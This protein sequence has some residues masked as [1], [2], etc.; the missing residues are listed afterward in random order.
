MIHFSRLNYHYQ[1]LIMVELIANY[2]DIHNAVQQD[3]ISVLEVIQSCTCVDRNGKHS[4]GETSQFG[5]IRF[6]VLISSTMCQR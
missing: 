2:L 3:M 1:L 6:C 4:D 5:T